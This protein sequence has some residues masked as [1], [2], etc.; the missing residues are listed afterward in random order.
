MLGQAFGLAARSTC[1]VI[2]GP[3]GAMSCSSRQL[4][5]AAGS[6][7]AISSAAT[8]AHPNLG[9][10]GVDARRQVLSACME[11][12]AAR[13]WDHALDAPG[14]TAL[15]TV[16]ERVVGALGRLVPGTGAVSRPARRGTS[17][18]MTGGR[19]CPRA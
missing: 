6:A 17:T 1:E 8:G 15:D 2:I 16:S 14:R 12:I 9:V 4:V 19:A 18:T 3:M 13:R 7:I 5:V 11:L 10:T